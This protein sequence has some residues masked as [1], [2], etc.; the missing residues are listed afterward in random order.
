MAQPPEDQVPPDAGQTASPDPSRVRN[1]KAFRD[2]LTELRKSRNL[3]LRDLEKASDDGHRKLA[4]ATVSTMLRMDALPTRDF[5][6]RYL[7]ACG[8][9]EEELKPWLKR[10]DEL[11][12]NRPGI[13]AWLRRR[14]ARRTGG[15]WKLRVGVGACGLIALIAGVGAW[16]LHDHHVH[17]QQAQQRQRFKDQHCGTL[18][19]GLVTT[20]VECSGISD[21][22]GEHGVFGSDLTP[23]M[24]AIDAEN[25]RV[26][27]AGDY[28]TIAFL[29]PLS[30]KSTSSLTLGQDVAELEG[31]YTAVEEENRK[32]S[33]PKIRLVVA[34]MSSSEKDWAQAVNRLIEMKQ[35]DHLVAVAGLGLS[36]QESVDAARALSKADLPMVSD[37]ITADGF[38][39]T[40]DI[41]GKGPINGLA[42][43]ALTNADQLTA[44][45]KQLTG[46]HT[47]ALVST[48][49]T[50]GGTKDLY[51]ASLARDFRTIPE[52]SKHLNKAADFPFDPRGGPSSVLA[53]ISQNL[54]NGDE[55]IDT[56]YFAIRLKYLPDF[57]DALTNRS[58]HTRH[59]TVVTGSDAAALDRNTPAL[60]RRDAPITVLYASFPSPAQLHS[61][62][63]TDHGL[64]DSF[65]KDFTSPHHGQQFP[66]SRL[67]D[68]YWPLV[69]HDAVLAVTTAV[70]NSAASGSG[71]AAGL[72]NRYAVRDE[73]YTLR[74]DAVAGASGH[75]GIDSNGDRTD[76]AAITTV[77]RLGQPL[78]N[79][80]HSG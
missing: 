70:H 78:N 72:P 73:L 16:Q 40:G 9:G 39:A 3:N 13:R 41:D 42:G 38:D 59:I 79:T 26:M 24:T 71:T 63:N 35:K 10:W 6:T 8:L 56:V 7:R 46:D 18:D 65:V 17:E 33:K 23:V 44:I 58:C 25:S 49:K 55:T 2:A 43:V 5:T 28:V 75:F 51:T 27:A 60:N 52:L 31:A 14:P 50:P 67:T 62:D 36:Q 12:G 61:S 32:D 77:H 80:L 19:A 37:L 69:A 20:G 29:T 48:D 54:C 4:A 74:T 45:S 11:N 15:R 47:A 66:A 21:G 76:T 53:S 64:Y 57:L 1:A 34:N 30:S 22:W 68:S